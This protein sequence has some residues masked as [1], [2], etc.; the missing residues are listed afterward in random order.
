M[1]PIV[2]SK[3]AAYATKTNI[4]FPGTSAQKTAALTAADAR[5]EDVLDTV[6]AD[7]ANL[8]IPNI[9]GAVI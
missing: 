4:Q 1:L 6:S 5:I 8:A 3:E 9:A 2:L 7:I